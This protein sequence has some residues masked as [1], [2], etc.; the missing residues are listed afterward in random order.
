MWGSTEPDTVKICD[1]KYAPF[2]GGFSWY[3][4]D[5]LE[6]FRK[7]AFPNGVLS[8]QYD[9][10][11]VHLGGNWHIPTS[12][13]FQELLACTDSEWISLDGINGR[14]F[15]SKTN[16]NSIFIPAAG[17]RDSSSVYYVG[18]YADLWSST[19]LSSN[20]LNACVLDFSSG[21]CSVYLDVRYYGFSMRPVVTP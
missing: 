10:A 18:G 9:A 3:N 20:P 14:K 4:D 1:W 15:I 7:E 2:N 5:M 8:D 19:L 16:G 13:Q 21:D 11:H 12:E 17:Y 6:M